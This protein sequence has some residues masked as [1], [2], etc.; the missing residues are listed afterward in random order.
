MSLLA[1]P[2]VRKWIKRADV[3]RGPE[4]GHVLGGPGSDE[5]LGAGES[6]AETGE[7]D[8]AQGVSRFKGSAQRESQDRG[9]SPVVEGLAGSVVELGGDAVE[10]GL[11]QRGQGRAL[12]EY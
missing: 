10:V 6:R 12:G 2:Q 8:P 9:G 4:G 7:R 11:G 1:D 5:G 3:D